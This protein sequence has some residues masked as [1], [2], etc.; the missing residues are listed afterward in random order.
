VKWKKED[1]KIDRQAGGIFFVRVCVVSGQA[2]NFESLKPF[3]CTTMIKISTRMLIQ[4]R[5]GGAK[6]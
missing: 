5:L 2:L 4:A 3:L 1:S 6:K